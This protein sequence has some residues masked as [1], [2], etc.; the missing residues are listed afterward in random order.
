MPGSSLNNSEA[1][2]V[3]KALVRIEKRDG[4]IKPAAV[5]KEA[6]PASSPLHPHFTWDDNQAAQLY[7]EDEARNLIRSVR[8]IRADVPAAEQECVR[9]LVHVRAHDHEQSFDGP[10][11]ISVA[12]ALSEKEYTDQMLSQ[13]KAEIVSWE[14]RYADLIR[15][16]KSQALVASLLEAFNSINSKERA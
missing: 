12:R 10:A 6:E 14:R 3:G 13:A 9:A 15:V 5:V 2:R 16:T 8:I 4:A 1:V 11:Y 7:R